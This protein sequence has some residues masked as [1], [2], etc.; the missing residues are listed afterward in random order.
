MSA[1]LGFR[2][3]R[4][5]AVVVG[6]A[7]EGSGPRLVLSSVLATAA[8]GDR[9]AMEPYRV[10][11]EL[12]R[13]AAGEVPA[14]AAAAVAEGRRRQAALAKQGLDRIVATLA[15]AGRAPAV[16]A[17]LVNRAG[18]IGDLLAYSLFAPEH[19]AVAEGLAVRDALRAAFA[20]RG[21]DAVEMDEKSL[22]EAASIKLGLSP[23]E[24][25]AHLKAMG[26]AA[27]RPWRKDQK[28]ACLA[29]WVAARG[30]QSLP[31]PSGPLDPDKKALSSKVESPS[32]RVN[33]S[34]LHPDGL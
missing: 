18:W 33:R 1:A 11:A 9:L 34:P 2:A 22:T 8:E 19:P 16:A 13:G 25:D 10:A 4:G 20:A 32:G 15:E 5:G 6:V 12:A 26:V 17:L 3:G 27:G 7:L 14:E 29:A 24:I 31:G 21:L 30:G 28:Q 23:A